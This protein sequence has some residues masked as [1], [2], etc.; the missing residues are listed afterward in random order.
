MGKEGEVERFLFVLFL[1][2][3]VKLASVFIFCFS[4]FEVS[5]VGFFFFYSEMNSCY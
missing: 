1:C 3:F 5:L 2:S 4:G